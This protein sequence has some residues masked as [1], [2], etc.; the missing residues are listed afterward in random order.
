MA[1]TAINYRFALSLVVRCRHDAAQKMIACKGWGVS[2]LRDGVLDVLALLIIFTP[3][4]LTGHKS[5]PK[6]HIVVNV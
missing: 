5:R 2:V 1:T 3:D 4:H 6:T